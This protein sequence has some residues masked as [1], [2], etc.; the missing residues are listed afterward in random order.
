MKILLVILVIGLI[1]IGGFI[2]YNIK[3]TEA[4]I[5]GDKPQYQGPVPE[6]YDESHFRE[7]G[8]TIPLEVRE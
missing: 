7:T 5:M 2:D 6:G 4:K 3:D 1:V 8:E